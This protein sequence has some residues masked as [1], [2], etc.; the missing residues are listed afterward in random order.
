LSFDWLILKVWQLSTTGARM[1]TFVKV[2]ALFMGLIVVTPAMAQSP[3]NV[4][5]SCMVDTLSG[6][7][8]K[9]LAKWIFF[10]IA[11]HP[12][13]KSYS[14]ASGQDIKESDQYVGKLITRLLTVSCP[15]ELK[16]ANKSDPLAVQKAFE[17]VGQ[18]AMQELMT[19]QDVMKTL[20]NYAQYADTEK[21]KKI[22]SEK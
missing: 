14:K 2:L 12:E 21:I 20:S 17:L 16:K 3:T 11:A 6:K 7:E 13:I 15:E 1:K 4:F 8:R 10:S 18:V 22:L 19:N 5:A 9:S